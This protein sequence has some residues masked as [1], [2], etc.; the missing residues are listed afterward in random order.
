DPSEGD[1]SEEQKLEAFRQTMLAL[2]RRLTLLVSLP[3]EKLERAL[4]QASA[5]DLAH[6]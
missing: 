4:L 1:G 5:R 2:H 6:S 3:P